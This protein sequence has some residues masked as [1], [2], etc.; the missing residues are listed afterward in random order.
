M[1]DIQNTASQLQNVVTQ[2]Q[3]S[4]SEKVGALKSTAF[5]KKLVTV[6]EIKL[7]AE[8][9][10]SKEY[11]GL[12]VINAEGEVVTVTTFQDFCKALGHSYEKINQDIQN[13]STFG[14][15]FLETS[16][17]MG[18]G[19]RDLRKLRKLPEE[20]QAIIINGEAVQAGDKDAVVELLEDVIA[21]HAKERAKHEKQHADAEADKQAL[22]QL[23][24]A[25]DEKINSL[26]KKLHKL[27]NPTQ[28]EAELAKQ[29]AEK[30]AL[31]QMQVAVNNFLGEVNK[32]HLSMNTAKDMSDTQFAQ[33]QYL[34]NI[35]MTYQ[36]IAQRITDAGIPIDFAEM[37]TPA[38]LTQE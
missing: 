14:E 32:F 26:D 11:K 8:I 17:R 10:E 21:K 4:L 27:T 6:T 25:K 3:I 5:L 2:D 1:N 23:V 13:L 16:Q 31:E 24:K 30:T 35:R 36:S 33:E 7:I 22:E 18:L 37:V 38:W 15:E 34:A 29:E 19:Y 12:S 9:K 20:D 28:D